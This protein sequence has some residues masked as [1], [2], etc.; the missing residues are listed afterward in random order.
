[1][2]KHK[3]HFKEKL[4]LSFGALEICDFASELFSFEQY[5]S[6]RFIVG[7]PFDGEMVYYRLKVNLSTRNRGM[8]GVDFSAMKKE[9][10]DVLL[11]YFQSQYG[12]DVKVY[13]WRTLHN[14]LSWQ[15]SPNGKFMNQRP[16]TRL[17]PLGA[18]RGYQMYIEFPNL[19]FFSMEPRVTCRD[20]N[21]H[22]SDSVV[23][24]SRHYTPGGELDKYI[25][26]NTVRHSYPR[27]GFFGRMLFNGQ[28]HFFSLQV[29]E[30]ARWNRLTRPEVENGSVGCTQ[31]KC[32]SNTITPETVS[33]VLHR[34]I[35][36]RFPILRPG[37]IG[38]PCDIEVMF[39]LA[40][41]L[42]EKPLDVIRHES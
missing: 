10:N 26:A 37:T 11:P 5:P 19:I 24:Y 3:E 29:P 23:F 32:L 2:E 14:F 35:N 34:E 7:D 42:D 36:K 41:C 39:T 38:K 30:L 20:G 18:D 25:T 1:M 9:L 28:I 31:E 21:N 16:G 17:T 33:I 15:L 12:E 22:Q 4:H 6:G 27:D 8:K 40:S 13:G